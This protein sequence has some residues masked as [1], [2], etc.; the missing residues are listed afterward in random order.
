MR[1]ERKKHPNDFV[2]THSPVVERLHVGRAWYPPEFRVWREHGTNDWLLLVAFAG[3]G[4]FDTTSGSVM[5]EAHDLVLVRP[6]VPHDYTTEE[7]DKDW[8]Q[9]WIHFHPRLEWLPWMAWPEAVPGILKL[10]LDEPIV[11]EK[12]VGYLLETQRLASGGLRQRDAFAMNAL[13]SA[14]LWC[15]T[16]N[17]QAGRA[18]L[19]GRVLAVMD[20]ISQRLAQPI[21][22]EDLARV[23]GLSASRMAHL[24]R[25]QIGVPPARFL[26]QQRLAYAKGALGRNGQPV[27]VLATE[28]GMDPPYFS[29]WFKRHTGVSPR[30]YRGRE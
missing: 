27:A 22:P 29:H 4:R 28:L 8:D 14:L 26:D 16:Q 21:R 25:A 11:R 24:F 19:D 12:I 9:F 17:A 15:D 2:H 10:H 13:E 23:G 6:G 3:I 30:D 7:G 5:I 1:E 20:F 18:R